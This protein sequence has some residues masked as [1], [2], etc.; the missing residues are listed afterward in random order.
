MTA[1]FEQLRAISPWEAGAALLGL[2][3][4]LLAVRRNLLCWLSAFASV[5]IY[6]VI[7]V[8]AALYMQSALH[9]FYLVV[10]VYGFIEWRRG[11]TAGGELVIR[12]WGSAEH[13]AAALFVLG[14]AAIN[15]WLLDRYTNAS[16]PFLDAFV[17]WGSVVAT[18][19]AARRVIE[20][21]L[22]WLVIDALA[23]YLYFTQALWPT[24]L[25]YVIYLGVVVQGYVVWRRAQRAQHV[26]QAEPVHVAG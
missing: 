19:M 9:V 26:A 14:T 3:Y 21:W 22:Y 2:G 16:A 12:S 1:L 4:T 24:T 15:G 25:L 8:K 10:A 13:F 23:A 18:W 7:F 17:T 5:S 11:R 6:T 20:N